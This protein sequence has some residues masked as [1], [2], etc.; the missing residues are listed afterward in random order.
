M[1]YDTLHVMSHNEDDDGHYLRSALVVKRKNVI[2]SPRL[3]LSDQEVPMTA[4]P[5]MLH[6]VGGPHT[7]YGPVEPWVRGQ[8][9]IRFIVGVL[10]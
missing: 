2:S 10:C 8:E 7:W 9:V 1:I 4:D 3:A 6:K 5:G